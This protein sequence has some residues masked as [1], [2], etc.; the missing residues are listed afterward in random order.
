M[1]ETIDSPH[2]DR[3]IVAKRVLDTDQDA[4]ATQIVEVVAELENTNLTDLSPIYNCID[5]LVTDLFSSPPPEEADANIT[6]TYRGYRIHVQQDGTTTF[7]QS[8]S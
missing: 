8:P 4:P 5:D 7:L 2:S 3:H 1:S 6:F